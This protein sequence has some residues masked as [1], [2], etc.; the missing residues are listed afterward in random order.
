MNWKH[1]TGVIAILMAI[2]IGPFV[3][4]GNS[5][6]QAMYGL[7]T[8]AVATAIGVWASWNYSRNSDK[9]RLTRYGLLAWRNVDALSVKVRQQ[10]QVGS[11]NIDMLQ[12]WLLDIDQAKW[13][14]R[15]LLRELFELQERLE[16]EREEIS[17]KYKDKIDATESESERKKLEGQS[18]IELAKISARA[19]LPIPE[20]QQVACPSCGNSVEFILG[21]ETGASAW[22]MC[23]GC[24][25]IFPVHR[26]SETDVAVNADALKLPVSKNCPHCS[27]TNEWKIPVNRSVHFLY[28]CTSCFKAMQCHGTASDFTVTLP[29]GDG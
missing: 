27:A 17:Q 23:D 9:E 19:P 1:V 22:P 18:R 4:S 3:I 26:K 21:T 12:S 15:D 28:H 2:F 29:V 24:G 20:K 16:L 5:L 11:A 8:A 14:W 25:A 10:I 6:A 13:G 7:L